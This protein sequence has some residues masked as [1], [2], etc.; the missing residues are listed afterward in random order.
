MTERLLQYIWQ[1]QFFNKAQL[2]T[3]EGENV[4]I[5]QPG[6]FNLNQGP[7]FNNARIRRGTTEWAGN[8]E[9]HLRSSDWHRHDHSPDKNYHNIILHVVWHHDAEIRDGNAAILP[10]LNIQPLVA[11]VL[12]QRYQWLMLS[13]DF[14]P[15]Q[16]QLPLLNDLQ[17][18]VWKERLA[19]ERL[20][21]KSQ[22]VLTL[23][24]QA[25]C[26]W[27]EVFWW[28]LA[29][30]FGIKVNADVFETVAKSLPLNLLARHK[31]QIHQIEA[32]LLGQAGLL[33]SK[34]DE[35]YPLLLQREYEFLKKKYKLTTA[36]AQPFFL[37]MRPANFPTIRL[38][39]LAM[40]IHQS[41]HLFSK[42]KEAV[43]VQAVKTLLNVT[44]NDYWHY[45][46]RFDEPAEYKVK[47]LG[48]Q[49]TEN[50]IINTVAPVLFAYGQYTN[51]QEWKEKAIK[52]L[53]DLSP[54]QNTITRNWKALGV[55][56]ANAMESQAL[57]ELKK[58]LLQCQT[59]P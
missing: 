49:M 2:V 5:L 59:L 40:L 10:T 31:H 13:H 4:Q 32:L 14:V 9:L 35:D 23:F 48:M 28:M 36:S 34:F 33:Q 44:A 43:D 17:W 19:V 41:Q 16:Q 11:K 55:P 22:Q 37:R 3:E 57:I 7:D 52:M 18:L 29:R 50:I 47:Q 45:H 12:L 53:N 26:H 38:A 15:C 30:N 20:Q 56:G 25:N 46:Y 8:I 58:Q 6:T 51:Q 42:I 27:E 24:K 54:E 39:Q 1:F 21:R